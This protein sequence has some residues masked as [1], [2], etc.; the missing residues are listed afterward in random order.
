MH[1]THHV[2]YSE[3]VGRDMGVVVYGHW[4]PPLLAFPTTGGDEWEYEQRGLINAV[5]GPIDAGRVKLYCINSNHRDGLGNT[6]A[7]PAH[8]SYMQRQYDAYVRDEVIPYIRW[9]CQDERIGIWT[10][11]ASLGAYHAVNTLLKYP[12][13]VKR[14]YA[15]SGTYD[16]KRF[17]NGWYDDHVYFNNPVDY[18]ANL[19]DSWYLDHLSS[20]EIRLVTGTGP[21]ERS[22]E[23]YRLAG[24]LASRGIPHSLD[25]W[26]PQGGHDWPYWITQMREYLSRV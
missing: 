14:C 26:G 25:D 10:M 17:L 9:H 18:A 16:V 8:R 6:G 7:H 5:A 23:S 20:C 21:W 12:D 11:G 2:W 15:L 4:G 13:I 22:E 19:T 24:V 3:R 1:R